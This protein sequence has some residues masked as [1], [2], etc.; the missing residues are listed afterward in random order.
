MG[1]RPIAGAVSRA[2]QAACAAHRARPL[3]VRRHGRQ[4]VRQHLRWGV[5]DSL[6]GRSLWGTWS[7]ARD[8]LGAVPAL[9]GRSQAWAP[10][11]PLLLVCAHATHD[12]CCALRGR[13]VARILSERWP[14]ATWECSHLGGDRFAANVAVLPEG[15]VYGNLDE[16]SAVDVVAAHLGG[17]TSTAHLRGMSAYSPP[18]QAAVGHVL[19][20][21]AGTSFRDVRPHGLTALGEDRWLAEVRVAGADPFDRRVVIG[22]SWRP[23]ARLTCHAVLPTDAAEY[24]VI[25]EAPAVAA[26]TEPVPTRF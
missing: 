19:E 1:S 7:D 9:A 3:L 14:S 8:L 2:L 17:R 16:G 26:D 6:T 22:R 13:P 24:S 20:Q 15:V 21:V 18:M 12:V 25:E 4:P 23:P 5:V 11:A 10:T